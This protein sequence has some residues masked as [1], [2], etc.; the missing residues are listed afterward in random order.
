MT[1]SG[2][3]NEITHCVWRRLRLRENW[4]F[5]GKLDQEASHPSTPKVLSLSPAL[6]HPCHEILKSWESLGCAARVPE[7]QC[8][9]CLNR[10]TMMGAQEQ[11]VHLKKDKLQLYCAWG[12]GRRE[13][14]HNER[15]RSLFKKIHLRNI[16]FSKSCF[17][18]FRP[19]PF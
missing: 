6:W 9:A 4:T 2:Y 11:R 12:G 8:T 5:G 3:L 16:K 15:A 17:F 7:L 19:D 1:V 10:H 14:Q 13:G 18:T